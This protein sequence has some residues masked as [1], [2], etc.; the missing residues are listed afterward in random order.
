M[1]MELAI[2]VSRWFAGVTVLSL[3]DVRIE[4]I[5]VAEEMKS[6]PNPYN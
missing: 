2:G 6:S 3:L 5:V 1:D 4:S